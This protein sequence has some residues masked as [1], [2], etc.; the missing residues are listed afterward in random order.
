[1]QSSR[2]LKREAGRNLEAMW[3]LGRL[4]PDHKTIAVFHKGNGPATRKV[5][6]RFV[7]LCDADEGER[8]HRRQQVQGREHRDRNFTRA[9]V[10]RRR[11]QLEESVARYLSQLDT[12]DLQGPSEELVIKTE[13]LKEQE[14]KPVIEIGR[15]S[16]EQLTKTLTVAQTSDQVICF[17]TVSWSG[18]RQRFSAEV[19][20][21]QRLS[22]PFIEN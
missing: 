4:V 22:A 11:A 13:Y 18:R 19:A 20:T 8:G 7:E 12:I 15:K 5:C 17:V 10:E 21:Q 16:G 1:V 14:H 9:R 3:L 6:A 2:R